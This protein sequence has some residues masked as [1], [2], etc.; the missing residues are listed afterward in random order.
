MTV[1]EVSELERLRAQLA[2]LRREAS[3]LRLDND[4]LT[5]QLKQEGLPET[6][7]WLQGKV[8]NQ[9]WHLRRLERRVVAQ[10][11]I[12]R[13]IEELGR[14]LTSDE[15]VELRDTYTEGYVRE[16][17]QGEGWVPPKEP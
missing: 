11:A 2:E 12:L 8:W 14:G 16:A 15:W 6:T 10:R 5:S 1:T 3:S 9:K 4:L 7:R 13:R 17:W